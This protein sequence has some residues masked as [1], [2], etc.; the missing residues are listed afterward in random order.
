MDCYIYFTVPSTT[1]YGLLYIFYSTIYLLVHLVFLHMTFTI[2]YTY[3]Y[4]RSLYH[5]YR[6]PIHG[7]VTYVFCNIVFCNI[8]ICTIPFTIKYHVSTI[9]KIICIVDTVNF[10]N[11]FNWKK[12]LQSE[13]KGKKNYEHIWNLQGLLSLPVFKSL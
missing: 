7:K 9:K 10:E 4:Y 5:T 2:P 8:M 11:G 12:K 6:I 13:Q 3:G 1:E